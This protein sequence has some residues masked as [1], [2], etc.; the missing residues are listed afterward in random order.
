MPG[1]TGSGRIFHENDFDPHVAGPLAYVWPGSGLAAFTGSPAGFPPGYQSPYPGGNP[2]G[3]PSSIYQLEA[4]AYS[5][6]GSVLSS[7][8]DH[9]N[10]GSLILG[11]NFSRPCE[12]SRVFCDGSGKALLGSELFNYSRVTIYIP[13]ELG[14]SWNT[15]LISTTFSSDLSLSQSGPQDPIGPGWWVFKASGN[16]QFWPQHNYAEW[17]YVRINDVVAP[18][19]AGK[20][21][22]KIFLSK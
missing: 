9:Q 20:Y 18:K 17:Y 6:F 22:F 21:F 15:G 16:L 12:I 13:P 2:P 19:I 8:D 7:T 5:P 10:T 1:A 3:Q 11:L 4:N 14:L